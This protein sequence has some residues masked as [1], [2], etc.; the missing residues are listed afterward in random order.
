MKKI[1]I[2]GLLFFCFLFFFGFLFYSP[3]WPQEKT[4]ALERF[5]LNLNDTDIQDVLKLISAK[6]GINIITTPEVTGNVTLKLA[7]VTWDK[8]LDSVL[9]ICNLG[10]RKDENIITVGPLEKIAFLKKQNSSL[11]TEVVKLKYLDA[12]LIEASVSQLLSQQGKISIVQSKGEAG[13]EFTTGKGETLGK[14]KRATDSEVPVRANLLVI[15]DIPEVIE[16]I[17]A[18]IKK[19]DVRPYQVLIKTKVIEV[20]KN[21]LQ[22]MGVDWGT[23]SN[24]A[25]NPGTISPV[26]IRDKGSAT[27]SIGGNSTSATVTPNGF[28]PLY[29]GSTPV[30]GTFPFNEGA[31]VVFKKLDGPQFEV[32]AHALAQKGKTN[33]LSAPQV[34]ALN[35]QEATIL[36]G[37]KYPILKSD[38][39]GAGSTGITTVTLDYYQ[40][41][42]I[43][44]KVIP[45]VGAENDISMVI[46][47][48]VTSYTETIGDNKYP[49][50]QT[51]EAETRLVIKDG[52]TIVIGGLLSDQKSKTISGIPVLM[53]LPWVGKFFKRDTVSTTKT[54]LLIFITAMIVKEDASFDKEI[55]KSE[56][57][58]K[59]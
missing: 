45:Q 40:D 53:D 59:M 8:A 35:N 24:G 27:K 15:T 6:S 20:D 11:M 48:A 52:D 42:G 3:A 31:Q 50:I 17:V 22:D 4:V 19:I 16:K 10:Y 36:V 51:R 2:N 49:V 32:I 41:I 25:E 18:V 23:G 46:H 28:S 38:V 21:W 37:T 47:P 44:L 13:W 54:D 9:S 26:L 58:Q 39:T 56:Q 57:M 7:N 34:L 29:Q 55:K 30:A 14:Q 43:Q 5:S 1:H 12:Q 33:T